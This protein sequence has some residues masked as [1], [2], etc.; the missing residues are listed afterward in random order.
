MEEM[1]DTIAA[2]STGTQVSA[3][4]ILRI[5]GPLAV[6]IT[7]TVFRPASGNL[8]SA[9]PRRQMVYGTLLD[10]AGRAIDK[11]MAVAFSEGHSYTGEASA[12]IHCHGSPIV[13]AE[14]LQSLFAAGARQAE[15]GEFTRR[16]FLHGQ[17]DLTQAEAVVDLIE[18]DTTSAARS[19]LAQLG[20]ALRRRGEALYNRLLDIASQ[21]YAVVDYPDEDVEDLTLADLEGVLTSTATDLEELLSTANRGKILREGVPTAILGRPNAGKSSLFNALL[22]YDRAIVTDIAGTTRDTVE[23]KAVV[24]G[25]PLRLIDTAGLRDTMDTVEKLGVERTKEAAAKAELL[26]AVVDGSVPPEEEDAKV[27]RFCAATG[28][29]WIHVLSKRDLSKTTAVSM[30]DLEGEISAAVSISSVTGEGLPDL[31]KAVA[32]L[33]PQGSTPAGEILTNPRQTD[34]V[35][36]ALAAVERARAALALTPDAVLTDVEAAMRCLGELTGRTVKDDILDRIF[37]RFCVG[38]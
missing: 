26:L 33:F 29:P 27:L 24:G 25:V 15:R 10:R 36:R 17:M 1:T 2:L 38:K 21:F 7:D 28:K 22:G 18:A 32:A 19:A 30:A 13:L 3:I 5:S 16:A 6:Q 14:G 23:E 37:E 9:H 8:L 12:E 35:E 31:E 4:G 11:C 34:A 20:G